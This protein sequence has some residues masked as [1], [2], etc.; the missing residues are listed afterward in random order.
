[1]KHPL[2]QEPVNAGRE[3]AQGSRVDE[4][5]EQ[6]ADEKAAPSNPGRENPVR[7]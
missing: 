1:M 6:T 5:I 3:E 4:V 2:G 7:Q